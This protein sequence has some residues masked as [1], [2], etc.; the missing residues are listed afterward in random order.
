MFCFEFDDIFENLLQL[1]KADNGKVE[2]R[3]L[4]LLSKV[5][6]E[7]SPLHLLQERQIHILKGK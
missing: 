5:K 6:S 2:S 4:P 1:I 7:I 3:N